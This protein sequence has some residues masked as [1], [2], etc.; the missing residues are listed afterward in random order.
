MEENYDNYL[1]NWIGHDETNRINCG[2]LFEVTTAGWCGAQSEHN[3]LS[4]TMNKSLQFRFFIPYVRS[5]GTLS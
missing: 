1:T 3:N 5:R 2:V 4:L